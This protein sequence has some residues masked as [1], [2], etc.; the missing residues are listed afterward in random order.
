VAISFRCRGE[1]DLFS[2]NCLIFM[3]SPAAPSSA[4][5]NRGSA[6]SKARSP[7]ATSRQ[8]G[9]SRRGVPED[10]GRVGESAGGINSGY[11][12]PFKG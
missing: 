3:P 8:F 9:G 7:A 2:L 5:S 1:K 6:E 12:S 4:S 10:E 11:F